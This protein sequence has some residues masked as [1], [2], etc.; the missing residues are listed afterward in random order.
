MFTD[1]ELFEILRIL[2]IV[3]HLGNTEYIGK[4]AAPLADLSVETMHSFSS[5]GKTEKGID[6]VTI[7]DA[8]SLEFIASLL[9]VKKDSLRLKNGGELC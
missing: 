6:S 4:Y 1:E 5:L 3:L 2:A 7:K 9:E 8:K